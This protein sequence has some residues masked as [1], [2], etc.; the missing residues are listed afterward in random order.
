MIHVVPRLLGWGMKVEVSLEE[1]SWKEGVKKIG[2]LLET[3]YRK[4]H[5]SVL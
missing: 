1:I 4:F 2:L 5:S 3:I